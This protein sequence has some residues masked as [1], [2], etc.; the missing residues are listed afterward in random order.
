MKTEK[1]QDL[2]YELLDQW[3]AYHKAARELRSEVTEAF[4]NVANGVATN[5]NLGVLA[6]LESMERSE[7]KLQEK[8]NE[9]MNSIDK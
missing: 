2:F 9:L 5:P 4:A 1:A 6:M 3:T 8:M 7:R